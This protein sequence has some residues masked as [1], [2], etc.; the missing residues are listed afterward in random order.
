MKAYNISGKL[1]SVEKGF[2]L[3]QEG[4]CQLKKA[5][6]ISG[7]LIPVDEDLYQFRRAYTDLAIL[8]SNDDTCGLSF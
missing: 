2:I 5:Y 7:R 1:V 6:I 8:A 3:V 4:L